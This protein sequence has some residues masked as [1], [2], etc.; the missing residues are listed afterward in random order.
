VSVESVI[1]Q[2]DLL[3]ALTAAF[4]PLSPLEAKLG[5]L[6]YHELL[7]GKPVY[8]ERLATVSWLP[9]K[10]VVT[11]LSAERL[12]NLLLYDARQ[13]IVGFAGLSIDE[14]P[15]AMDVG[16]QTLYTWCAWDG[17]S[18]PEMIDRTVVLRTTCPQTKR[19]IQLTVRPD[20]V[21][22]VDPPETVLSFVVPNASV[23]QR[24]VDESRREFCDRVSFF[25]TAEAAEQ[26]TAREADGF[27]WALEDAFRLARAFNAARFGTQAT[28]S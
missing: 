4:P 21:E 16:T 1:A 3:Q 13:R 26:G 7:K 25:A 18:L 12:A 22:S 28:P 9:T 5:R 11:A 10:D 6:L 19:P 8:R 27:V 23:C 20:L 24:G 17:L 2:D 15:F 14:T